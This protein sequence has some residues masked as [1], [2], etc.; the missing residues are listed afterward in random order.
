MTLRTTTIGS[1]PKPDYV[2]IPDMF[3]DRVETI[4]AFTLSASPSIAAHRLLQWQHESNQNSAM[5]NSGDG[6]DVLFVVATSG[7][8]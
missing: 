5:G 2:A 1:Y 7:D 8:E 3:Q 4:W 6:F